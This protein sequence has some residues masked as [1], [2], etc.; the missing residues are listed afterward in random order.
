DVEGNLYTTGPGG[1][2]IISPDGTPLAHIH[3]P[4]KT[5]N[6]AWGEDRRSLYVTASTSIYRLRTQIPGA[7]PPGSAARV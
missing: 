7:P 4:E 2:W 3:F 5:A 1:L 6:C